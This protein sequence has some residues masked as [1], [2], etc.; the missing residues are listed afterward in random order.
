MQASDP[1]LQNRGRKAAEKG[2]EIRPLPNHWWQGRNNVETT[3][4]PCLF[5]TLC[6]WVS[7]DVRRVRR[8][9]PSCKSTA[10]WFNSDH[11]LA[12]QTRGEC[13]VFLR[14][15][16]TDCPRRWEGGLQNVQKL[17]TQGVRKVDTCWQLDSCPNSQLSNYRRKMLECSCVKAQIPYG[18][19]HALQVSRAR[20]TR[21]RNR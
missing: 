16:G 15:V 13:R 8:T 20:S 19:R 14:P 11:G 18:P 9:L 5:S 3:R 17:G 7:A 12:Q 1:T 4:F 6:F 10:T 21:E 2:L